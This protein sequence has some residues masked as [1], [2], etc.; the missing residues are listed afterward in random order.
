MYKRLFIEYNCQW[1]TAIVTVSKVHLVN[2][3][4][5]QFFYFVQ[6]FEAASKARDADYC[7]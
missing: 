2:V 1:H 4:L 7:Y 5:S 6:H 3:E